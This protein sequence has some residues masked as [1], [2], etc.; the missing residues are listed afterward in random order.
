[1]QMIRR[2]KMHGSDFVIGGEVG[3]RLVSAR[4]PEGGTR[5]T[6]ALR[7][8]AEDA[9]YRNTEAAQPIEV[10]PADKT[11]SGYCDRVQHYCSSPTHPQAKFRHLNRPL[12]Q[13]SVPRPLGSGLG[14]SGKHR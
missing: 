9:S 11:D 10:R 13:E 6:A 7:S 1:M 14:W 4:E 8:A 2:A 12:R 5:V 3:E